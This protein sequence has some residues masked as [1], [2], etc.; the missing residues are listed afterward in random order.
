MKKGQL[1]IFIIIGIVVALIFIILLI[2]AQRSKESDI[3]QNVRDTQQVPSELL[4]IVNFANTCIEGIANKGIVLLGVQGGYIYQ[5]QG[6]TKPDYLPS[7]QGISY[8]T[9]N[10]LAVPYHIQLPVAGPT[11]DPDIPGY[12]TKN[13][14][15]Y[16]YDVQ[17]DFTNPLYLNRTR[18]YQKDCF[19]KRRPFD[20][21]Q[22][23]EDLAS[24]M[25]TKIITDCKFN[26]ASFDITS[27]QPDVHIVSTPSATIFNVSYPLSIVNKN[28]GAQL[29][30]NTFRVEMD[31]ALQELYDFANTVLLSDVSDPGY[32]MTSRQG[33]PFSV[34]VVEN[35]YGKD[36]IVIVSSKDFTITGVPVKLVFARANR[37]P[38][39]N[40]VYNTTFSSIAF[41]SGTEVRWGDVF[42]QDITAADPDEDPVTINVYVNGVPFTKSSVYTITPRDSKLVFNIT[43]T[44]GQYID[45]QTG[46]YREASFTIQ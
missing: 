28:T 30:L 13:I 15:P 36:D 19:G 44:D 33:S 35:F 12:P 20:I 10:N 22:S 32:G 38:A 3:E 24:Y 16:P 43:V 1:T 26:F 37:Y 17:F 46:N 34:S 18:Y 6:G 29:S 45:F 21:A 40:Y 7:Q 5:K 11:C 39:L 31:L 8:L 25:E 2:I 27:G 4:P 42:H 14:Y 9:Y 41:S 23:F